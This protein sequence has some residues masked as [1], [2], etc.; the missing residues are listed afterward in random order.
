[1]FYEV[2]CFVINSLVDQIAQGDPFEFDS[3]T[4]LLFS[5]PMSFQTQE[6]YAY[7]QFLS[8]K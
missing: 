6:M 4:S 1:M 3:V 5:S 2:L 7:I 8:V